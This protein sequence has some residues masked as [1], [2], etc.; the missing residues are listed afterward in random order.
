[1]RV[2]LDNS[3]LT[4]AFRAMG[5]IK[6]YNRELFDLDIASLRL[7][8]DSIIF[9]DKIVV[10]DNYINEYSDERKSWLDYDTINFFEIDD[11]LNEAM[12]K[13]ARAHVV[14]WKLTQHL[15]TELSNMFDDISIMFKH[16]W[17]NSESFLVLKALGVEDKYGSTITNAL[18]EYLYG[19]SAEMD[20]LIDG[21]IKSYNKE[22]SKV[23][24]SMVW[25]SIRT[26]Y[27]REASQ[28]LGAEYNPHPLR[29]LYNTKCILFDNHPYTRKFK[30]HS[31]EIKN[32]KNAQSREEYLKS[33]D[34][35]SLGR[36]Y[37][38]DLNEFFRNFWSD[39]N[40][41]DDNIFGVET[42]D[43]DMPPFLALAL[44]NTGKRKDVI[45]A[46]FD[47]R[48][49]SEVDALRKK[50]SFIYDRCNDDQAKYIK[51]FAS[52]LRD[53]KNYLQMYLGYDREKVG[54]SV[55]LLSYDFT[56]PR[57]M[58]KP[59][60]PHKPHLAFIRDVIVELASASTMGRMIDKLWFE[61]Y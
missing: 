14:N 19:Q 1:M 44:K 43:I 34:E 52:E 18:R 56:V 5:K 20:K 50:L 58:T 27:Y 38:S 48:N 22:T 4:A 31:N 12:N 45:E 13:N 53:L 37:Y 8:V 9:S 2:L 25:A 24:Q 28:F 21:S 11:K 23:A 41:K 16:A 7:L 29:N 15:G 51:E 10:L 55:K 42:Y 32:L 61:R 46:A 30:L 60:Y 6:N 35:I 39:C 57:F 33:Y 3:T 47:I 59:L 26:V 49:R 54:V 40:S 17:R 36:Q